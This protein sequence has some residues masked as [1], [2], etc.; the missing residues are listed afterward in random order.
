MIRSAGAGDAG[1][2]C[3]IWNE[4]IATS[5]ATFTT[6]AKTEADI[7]AMIAARGET[8]LVAPDAGFATFGPFRS[9]PG[10][11]DAREVTI[12]LAQDAQ[13]K[14]LGAQMLN[15]LEERAQA[16]G[17]RTL[18][19]GTSGS[20]AGAIRFF[21]RAGYG[22]VARM[23]GIGQ[24]WGERLDLVLLQKNLQDMGPLGLSSPR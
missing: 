13:G 2:I 23:P 7:E 15:A 17:V 18:V 3:A 20:N 6:T 19:A 8:F 4:V 14:G 9:G 24:K 12:Y 10:Y 22:M 16:L 5:T 1:W 11:A 21:E